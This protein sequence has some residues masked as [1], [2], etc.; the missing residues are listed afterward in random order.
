MRVKE[1]EGHQGGETLVHGVS[2]TWA[3]SLAGE[4]FSGQDATFHICRIA[5]I[6]TAGS[7]RIN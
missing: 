7:G 6:L 3:L 1:R 5:I 2:K 4:V